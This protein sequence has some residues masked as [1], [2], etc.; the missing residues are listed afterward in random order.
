ML[1]NL[2]KGLKT[3]FILGTLGIGS[4]L[5][6]LP[7][8]IFILSDTFD[9]YSISGRPYDSEFSWMHYFFQDW[10][11]YLLMCWIGGTVVGLVILVKKRKSSP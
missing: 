1:Q 4:F 5:Y 9:Y 11:F 10:W 6:V 8:L 3:V 7:M 2:D